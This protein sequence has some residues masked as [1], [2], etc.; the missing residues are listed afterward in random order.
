MT[1]GTLLKHYVKPPIDTK[2][3]H[4]IAWLSADDDFWIVEWGG[5]FY[6]HPRLIAFIRKDGKW[7]ANERGCE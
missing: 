5:K 3:K 6:A 4:F 7:D 1:Y 2:D